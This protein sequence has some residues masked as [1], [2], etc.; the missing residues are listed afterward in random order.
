MPDTPVYLAPRWVQ[1]RH[2][3]GNRPVMQVGVGLRQA[4]SERRGRN[5]KPVMVLAEANGTVAEALIG[6]R[7][8]RNGRETRSSSGP[9][10][11]PVSSAMRIAA[12]ARTR[13]ID[14]VG[15]PRRRAVNA[16]TKNDIPVGTASCRQPPR[17]IADLEGGEVGECFSQ[18]RRMAP[19]PRQ[20]AREPPGLSLPEAHPDGVLPRC[21]AGIVQD[22][23]I[24]GIG[25]EGIRP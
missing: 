15:N 8:N 21:Q 22:R 11:P 14:L 4:E 16:I 1:Y 10:A 23:E 3:A 12:T 6:A 5:S 13:S 18:R 2:E 20:G 7:I 19:S 25:N 9:T 17:R 24:R